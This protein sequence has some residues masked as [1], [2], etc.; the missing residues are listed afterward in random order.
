MS[1]ATA[2]EQPAFQ[3]TIEEIMQLFKT[4]GDS[5]YGREAVSQREHAL[6]CAA[7]AEQ[8][9]AAP[10]LIVAALLHDIGHLLHNLPD[11]APN[12]GIDDAHEELAAHWLRTRFPSRVCEPVRLHVAAKRYL[13]ATDSAYHDQLSPP[14][15]Q[16]LRLQGGPMSPEEVT[17]FQSNPF[18]RDAITLRLWDDTAKIP[19]HPTPPVEHYADAI[20]QVLEAR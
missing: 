3:Q 10:A 6:Q 15:R 17:E 11:D 16:S 9:Q 5:Q 13:C 8:S 18:S 14:S 4:H 20:R 12:E 2:S 1:E 19:D 7:L